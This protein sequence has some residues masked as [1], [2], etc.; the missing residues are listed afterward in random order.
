MGTV[1]SVWFEITPFFDKQPSYLK[2]YTTPQKMIFD[3]WGA[4]HVAENAHSMYVRISADRG[5]VVSIIPIAL[6]TLY[7]QCL[8]PVLRVIERIYWSV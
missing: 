7:R 8:Y 3:R 4:D 6:V 5:G 1:S 2:H